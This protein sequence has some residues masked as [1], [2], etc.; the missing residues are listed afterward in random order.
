[1][2]GWPVTVEQEGCKPYVKRKLELSV[3]DGCLLW[4]SRVIVPP[5]GRAQVME[6]L[7][8]AHPGVSRM[9]SLARSFVWWPGMDRALEDQV[10]ACSK[11][12]SNQKMPAPA[13]LHP[14]QWPG[15]PW[16]RLHLD[17]AGPCMGKMFLV[18]VDAHSK[19]LE[20][21]I[22]SNITA[23]VTT[24][25][26][27]GIFAIH[28]LPD[29]IVTDNGPTFISEVFKE[30]NEKNGI[31]HVYTAPYHPASNGLAERAVE[32]LKD[33]LRKMSGHSR[34]QAFPFPVPVP[35]YSSHSYRGTPSGDVTGKEAEIS[36]GSPLPRHQ[37][38]SCQVTGGAES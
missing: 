25:T 37:G 15:H 30:F 4:G 12:Q 8:E 18:M 20:A 16:S 17:F 31:H 35:D 24:E 27:R 19:W 9:K 26:L 22:M 29:M 36:F 3:L 28:G 34:N 5:S 23:P 6:E 1:M 14:W 32:T 38:E 13:P 2:Q 33:G 10:K 21:H 7:H 11:C